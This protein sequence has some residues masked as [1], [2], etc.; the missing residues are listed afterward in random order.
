VYI[1]SPHRVKSRSSPVPAH[2]AAHDHVEGENRIWEQRSSGPGSLCRPADADAEFATW[3]APRWVG[4]GRAIDLT[5][6]I[7]L[8]STGTSI[9]WCSNVT[10]HPYGRSFSTGMSA[11]THMGAFGPA[12]LGF[13]AH[14][15]RHGR[16]RLARGDHSVRRPVQSLA[17]RASTT[18]MAVLSPEV[19]LLYK[20]GGLR[21]KDVADFQAVRPHLRNPAENGHRF[22]A[23]ADKVPELSGQG[24]G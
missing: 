11:P 5:L 7:R 21:D 4:G 24:S 16:R 3:A 14:D 23:K 10:R 1:A 17:G 13:S 22:R 18:T 19:Q 2:S 9:S 8:V 12:G 15:R 6:A 20:S